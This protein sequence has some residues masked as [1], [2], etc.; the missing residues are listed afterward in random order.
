MTMGMK[1]RLAESRDEVPLGRDEWNALA[2]RNPTC[3]AFQTFEWFDTWWAAFGPRHRLFLLT[4]HDGDRI[5]GIV[6]MMLV[7]GPLGLRQIEFIGI[8]NADYQD[9]ILPERR[10][11]AV[12][13]VCRFLDTERRRWDMIVFRD[14]PERS[15]TAGEFIAAF[16]GLGYGVMNLE[17]QPCPAVLLRGRESEIRRMPIATACGAAY[18]TSSSAGR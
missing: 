8:P 10:S 12:A 6:P 14:L 1:V 4:V 13:S 16:A 7:R 2:A 9:V 5:I 3:T 17:R 15:A 11:E 18:V